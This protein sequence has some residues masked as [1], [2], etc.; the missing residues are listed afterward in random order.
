MRNQYKVLQEA[1]EQT[2]TIW[3]GSCHSACKG[4]WYELEEVGWD[5]IRALYNT[6]TADPKALGKYLEYGAQDIQV[7]G[8]TP[9]P[10]YC[11]LP[12]TFEEFKQLLESGQVVRFID[13]GTGHFEIF[14][15]NKKKCYDETQ[16]TLNVWCDMV[17]TDY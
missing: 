4:A 15:L 14:C 16:E 1:Y 6:D 2:Q 13:H 7:Y 11:Y 5:Y 3:H 17:A 12:Q 9:F 10:L 8:V